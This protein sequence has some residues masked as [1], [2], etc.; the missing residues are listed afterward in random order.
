MSAPLWRCQFVVLVNSGSIA[1][2]IEISPLSSP[3]QPEARRIRTGD[4]VIEVFMVEFR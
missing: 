4:E 2:L 3:K 1:N